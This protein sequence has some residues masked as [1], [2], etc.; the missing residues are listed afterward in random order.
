M[1]ERKECKGSWKRMKMKRTSRW[2]VEKKAREF[3]EDQ[4]EEA[5]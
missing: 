3:Q 4:E 5:D 2:N 1:G